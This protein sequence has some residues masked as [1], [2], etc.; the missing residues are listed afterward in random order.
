MDTDRVHTLQEDI[1]KV[2]TILRV[3]IVQVAVQAIHKVHT[4]QVA[5]TKEVIVEAVMAVVTLV[6]TS[7]R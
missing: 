2:H 5:I 7:L 4:L 1:T 3:H 6:H